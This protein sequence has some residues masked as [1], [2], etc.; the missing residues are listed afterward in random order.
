[1]SGG[2]QGQGSFD[3]PDI[4]F[5]FLADPIGDMRSPTLP[6]P[7]FVYKCLLYPEFLAAD[8]L[9]NVLSYYN[10]VKG[11]SAI[12]WRKK[13]TD[14]AFVAAM[15]SFDVSVATIYAVDMERWSVE[16]GNYHET[17][18]SKKLHKRARAGASSGSSSSVDMPR[19]IKAMWSLGKSLENMAAYLPLALEWGIIALLRKF[20]ELQAGSVSLMFLAAEDCNAFLAPLFQAFVEGAL[21]S[22]VKFAYPKC[23]PLAA[24]KGL[25]VARDANVSVASASEWL[26]GAAYS[27]SIL[28]L[29]LPGLISGVEYV[30]PKPFGDL[31]SRYPIADVVVGNEFE[32]RGVHYCMGHAAAARLGGTYIPLPALG[33][34]VRLAQVS[35]YAVLKGLVGSSDELISFCADRDWVVARMAEMLA[36]DYLKL[37]DPGLFRFAL[38]SF[39]AATNLA[40]FSEIAEET[41][42]GFMTEPCMEFSISLVQVTGSTMDESVDMA[43][44]AVDVMVDVAERPSEFALVVTSVN[45]RA[46]HVA[47]I[48]KPA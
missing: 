40:K 44:F 14:E 12:V 33:G 32:G 20:E 23:P 4:L 43:N 25:L 37:M 30:G 26:P 5:S 47:L 27:E 7:W 8:A 42:W 35:C 45:G 9:Q 31:G 48:H 38:D 39:T 24:I 13:S 28:N 18:A 21:F 29:Y 11:P 36:D 41:K 10:F 3:E 6:F 2:S 19:L 22:N 34:C 17:L 1:M 16:F 46:G 15:N